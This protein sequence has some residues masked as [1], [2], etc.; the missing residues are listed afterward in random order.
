M[1]MVLMFRVSVTSSWQIFRS[2]G[3]TWTSHMGCISAGGPGML[4]M[5]LPFRSAHHPGAVPC[6]LGI[7]WD[8]GIKKACLMLWDGM[9]MP[10]LWKYRCSSLRAS[11][12]T[13]GVSPRAMATPSRVRSSWVGP[14][15]PV[16]MRMS[17]RCRPRENA[18]PRL[19]KSSP[20]I[21]THLS[22]IPR[23]GS[24]PAIHAALVSVSSPIRSSVPME[25]MSA[26]KSAP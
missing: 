22:C 17:E 3:S 9:E 24:Q 7:N 2:R 11:S 8:D 25:K 19:P 10:R 23:G 4:M 6:G 21:D 16:V 14:K 15:P 1:P 26:F 20:T 18:S 13:V 12:C 5:T